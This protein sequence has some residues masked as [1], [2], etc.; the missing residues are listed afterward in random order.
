MS[1]KHINRLVLG[2]V[3]AT[4]LALAWHHFAP[5]RVL[6]VDANSPFTMRA[7]D[8]RASGGKSRSRLLRGNGALAVECT[9][10]ASY[11]WPYCEI[12]V[13]LGEVPQGINLSSY[14]SLKIW[15]HSEG[16]EPQQQVRVFLRQYNPAY[17]K[18]GDSGS[19]KPME[20]VLEPG[21]SPQ[22]ME[23][24]LNAMSVASWWAAQHVVPA[25]FKGLE[26]DN[27]VALDIS[28]AGNVQPG[29]HRI[30][31]ERMEFVGGDLISAATLQLIIIAAWLLAAC[32]Y[33][34]ADRLMMQ[35]R[36]PGRRSGEPAFGRVNANLKLQAA[37]FAVVAGRDP[38]TGVYNRA[39]L[40]DELQH[41]A[42]R[43]GPALFPLALLLFDIDNFRQI[44]EAHG[45]DVGDLVIKGAAE[46]VREE[47]GNGELVARWGGGEFLV[48]CPAISGEAGMVLAQRLRMRIGAE[49][50]P[51]GQPVTCSFGVSVAL[52]GEKMADAV[53]RAVEAMYRAKI[54]GRDRVEMEVA[55]R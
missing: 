19:Y 29:A 55:L 54:N 22:P 40:E 47:L 12:N 17:S 13:E 1:R 3:L 41:L 15:L 39:G 28:T 43:T 33:L 45:G 36:R 27:I 26:R 25:Q 4:L 23:L 34:V 52:Q 6:V 37:P 42:D 9:I 8:D 38:L 49:E 16:P 35:R 14:D 32:G 5:G 48:I 31:V 20:M 50:W 51:H 24:K 18:P 30:V 2:L 10:D 21:T 53:N 46:L 7:I 44:N 11:Q